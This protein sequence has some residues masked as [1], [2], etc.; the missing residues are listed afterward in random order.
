MHVL[1]TLTSLTRFC[2]RFIQIVNGFAGNSD[3]EIKGKVITR[4]HNITE[5][6]KMLL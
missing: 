3:A 2:Y 6:Q 5:L 1:T 4:L